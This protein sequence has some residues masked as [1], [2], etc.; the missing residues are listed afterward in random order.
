[1]CRGLPG[2]P[3]P[4]QSRYLEGALKGLVIGCLYLPN[5]N[6]QPGPKFDYKLA[7]LERLIRHAASLLE[8]KVPVVLAGD[9]N[10]V[11]T[12]DDIYAT[13]SYEKNALVQPQSRA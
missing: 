12:P 9:F 7:W 8:A 4:S 6:P 10:V 2:D 5:G 13:K 1:M 3:D 11:P